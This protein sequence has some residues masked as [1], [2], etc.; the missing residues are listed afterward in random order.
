MKNIV[1]CSQ[2]PETYKNIAQLFR[3]TKTV[4]QKRPYGPFLFISRGRKERESE[5]GAEEKALAGSV[6]PRR[7]VLGARG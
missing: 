2:T 5:L 1:F 6:N 3:T 4:F 7:E